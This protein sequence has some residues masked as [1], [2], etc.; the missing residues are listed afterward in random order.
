MIFLG[1]AE[2]L[3][4]GNNEL[5]NRLTISKRQHWRG[6]LIAAFFLIILFVFLLF[7]AYFIFR[8]FVRPPVPLINGERKNYATILNS[9][10]CFFCRKKENNLFL[11]F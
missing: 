3:N 1:S 8:R 10:M 2:P 5:N 7:M 4:K 11:F 6:I 9:R